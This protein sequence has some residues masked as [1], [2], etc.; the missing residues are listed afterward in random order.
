MIRVVD[1]AGRQVALPGA[2]RRVVSLVPSVT[3]TLCALG[4]RKT[5][6]GITRHCVEPQAELQG[7]ARVGGT[8][9]PDLK[10]IVELAPD[11]VVVNMEENRRADFDVLIRAGLQVFVTFVR[12]PAE[13]SGLLRRLGMLLDVEAAA[14]AEAAALEAALAVVERRP[15]KRPVAV[16]C[17]IWKNP[18]MTFS[19]DTFAGAMLRAVGARSVLAEHRERYPRVT[20][21]EVAAAAP[22]MILLPDEPYVFGERDLGALAPLQATPAMKRGR[23]RFADGK[24]LFWFGTRTAAALSYLGRLTCV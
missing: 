11:L 21:E 12:R 14:G 19:D 8:K 3:E 22:E 24:A 2:P 10:R 23:V 20:L 6:V 5:L 1:D 16:F 17:P 15:R 13:V 9:N 18:W 7:V 4:C